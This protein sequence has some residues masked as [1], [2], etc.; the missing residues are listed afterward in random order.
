MDG[1]SKH[2]AESK[3]PDKKGNIFY[4]CIYTKYLEWINLQIHKVDWY[5]PVGRGRKNG[6]NLF[7]TIKNLYFRVLEMFLNQVELVAVQHC[8]CTKWH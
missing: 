5:L 7:F 3:K 8:E 1:P 4:D 6:E 2:Y